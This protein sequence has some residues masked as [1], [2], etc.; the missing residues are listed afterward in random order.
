MVKGKRTNFLLSEKRRCEAIPF[1]ALCLAFIQLA[2]L[3]IAFPA[4]MKQF[5]SYFFSLGHPFY[6]DLTLFL[7]VHIS[8]LVGINLTMFCIYRAKH[9]F[10]E[11]YRSEP[12]RQFPW[13]ED[14]QKWN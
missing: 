11:Q 4:I 12:E 7:A 13:E 6:V 2:S 14:S 1:W 8:A 9:P 10:F 3:F 5:W